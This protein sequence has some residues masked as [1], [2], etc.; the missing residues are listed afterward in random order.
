MVLSS[1]HPLPPCARKPTV[2]Q[3]VENSAGLPEPSLRPSSTT[4][5]ADDILDVDDPAEAGPY[6]ARMRTENIAIVAAEAS[7]VVEDRDAEEL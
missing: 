6:L 7:E 3:L 1:T 4:S 2:S 5:H